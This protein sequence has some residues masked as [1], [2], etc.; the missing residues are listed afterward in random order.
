MPLSTRVSNTDQPPANKRAKISRQK[1]ST[2]T[3]T[4]EAADETA[5]ATAVTAPV[6]V[7]D[8]KNE[9]NVTTSST[10]NDEPLVTKPVN[11]TNALPAT[12]KASTKTAASDRSTRTSNRNKT[13]TLPT[14]VAPVAKEIE[15]VQEDVE[16]AEPANTSLSQAMEVNSLEEKGDEEAVLA[17]SQ[18]AIASVTT[19]QQTATTSTGRNGK[20]TPAKRVSSLINST[21]MSTASNL[22]INNTTCITSITVN[23]D[24]MMTDISSVT[25]N[26]TEITARGAASSKSM[27]G[28]GGEACVHIE[29]LVRPG[30]ALAVGE[31]LSNQLGLG[32]DIDNRK[33]PQIIKEL[34]SNVIH[35]ASG[36]M[37]SACLTEDGI[38]SL[39]F[40]IKN[41][42]YLAECN[43]YENNLFNSCS[44]NHKIQRKFSFF[45]FKL[46]T[47]N[48][49][50]IQF[51]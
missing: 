32:A 44:Q 45:N 20:H 23:E 28:I 22:S 10:E 19:V 21:M 35:V 29:R 15:A 47:T 27:L 4:T 24:S 43:M 34:P 39:D 8:A 42:I 3:A 48:F 49:N 1:S 18:S 7:V 31:N 17:G 9:H 38:V 37:H 11:G 40:I 36:G 33:K 30:Y 50:V 2:T 46:E 26:Q 13:T 41:S 12:T 5:T 16:I 51:F 6:T 25:T 14:A